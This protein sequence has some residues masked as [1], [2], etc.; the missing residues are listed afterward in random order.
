MGDSVGGKMKASGGTV[1][2][3]EKE[4]SRVGGSRGEVSTGQAV[5]LRGR[6]VDRWG[7]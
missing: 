2:T 1:L 5:R 6:G 3:G 7:R 4:E